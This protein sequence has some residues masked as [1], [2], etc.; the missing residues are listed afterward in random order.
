[1]C[2]VQQQ[3]V[4]K[5][6]LL[7]KRYVGLG[8]AGPHRDPDQRE[9]QDQKQTA[10]FWYDSGTAGAAGAK[11]GLPHQVVKLANGAYRAGVPVR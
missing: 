6:R 10:R 3:R 11:I 1:M 4:A 9:Q 7:S 2:V 8:G 5:R